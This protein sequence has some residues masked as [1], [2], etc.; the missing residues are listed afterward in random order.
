[1]KPA[2]MNPRILFISSGATVTGVPVY[3]VNL[4]RWLKSNTGFDITILTAFGGPL[5]KEYHK[6]ATVYKWDGEN[7]PSGFEKYYLFRLLRRGA[8]RLFGITGNQYQNKIISEIRSKK[9]DLIYINSVCSLW[10]FEQIRVHLQSKVILHVHELQMSILQF[11]GDEMFR[12]NVGYADKIIVISEAVEQNLVKRY[13]ISKAMMTQVYTFV[14]YDRARN[15]DIPGQKIK[16][17][18]LLGIPDKTFIVVSS[19]T[20]DWRKG[21]DLVVHIAKKVFSRTDFPIHFIWLGGDDSGLDYQKL[22]YDLEKLNFQDRIHFLGV[23]ENFLEYLAVADIFMLTSREEPVGIVGL[24]A[25]ALGIP[26]LC[27]DQ[28]GGLP[29]FVGKDSGFVLPYLDLDSMADHILLLLN[30]SELRTKLGENAA[31]KVK[32][33]D[34]NIACRKIETV[35]NSIIES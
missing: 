11:C 24:E 30:D 3:F 12:R 17:K 23:R 28:S 22:Y 21:A 27:F 16:I 13:D 33:L 19:G 8:I 35:I 14:D 34:I 15:T 29:E 25:A 7:E 9:F 20:T 6:L 26:V 1:M 31:T 10:I 18:S 5:E 2:K 32:Q 4:I